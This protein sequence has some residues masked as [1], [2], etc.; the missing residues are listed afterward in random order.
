MVHTR[1]KFV[2]APDGEFVR[3]PRAAS[4]DTYF[5]DP[6]PIVSD[7]PAAVAA[8]SVEPEHSCDYAAIARPMLAIDSSAII[9]I[10]SDSRGN[11]LGSTITRPKHGMTAAAFRSAYRSLPPAAKQVVFVV[12]GGVASDIRATINEYADIFL[13]RCIDLITIDPS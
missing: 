12:M 7:V 10:Y 13:C 1:Y 3:I 2:L 4:R 8:A 9:A 5:T 6:E 11:M